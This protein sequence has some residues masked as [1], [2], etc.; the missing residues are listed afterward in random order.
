MLLGEARLE[1]DEAGLGWSRAMQMLPQSRGTE[2]AAEGAEKPEPAVQHRRSGR[3]SLGWA[4][5]GQLQCQAE[6]C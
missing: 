2:Q 4:C 6:W 3:S 1:T 5:P